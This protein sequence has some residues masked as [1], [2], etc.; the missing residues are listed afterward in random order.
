VVRAV[1]LKE[2]RKMIP[3]LKFDKEQT[4]KTLDS[5]QKTTYHLTFSV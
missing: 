2:E 4:F 1:A 3:A 5:L